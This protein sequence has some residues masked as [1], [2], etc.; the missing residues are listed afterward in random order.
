[1]SAV[2]RAGPALGSFSPEGFSPGGF[3][4]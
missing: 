3:S 2:V 4:P 1:M